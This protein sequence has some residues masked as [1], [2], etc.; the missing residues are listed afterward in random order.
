MTYYDEWAAVYLDLGRSSDPRDRLMAR[1]D[2][3]AGPDGC[4]PYL[5]HVNRLGYGQMAITYPPA[6]P[7]RNAM[8]H[9]F[10]FEVLVG[11]IPD[12]LVLDHLCRNRS[13]CNPAHLEPVTLAENTRRGGN[14]IK[15]ACKRGHEFS[16]ENTYR[17][18]RG[19]RQ[20]KACR[21]EH[22]RAARAR[23]A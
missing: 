11:P 6:A 10:A 13:C 4:W 14:A 17:D 2:R 8:A 23:A 18:A 15:T 16:D 7:W 3:S 1:I 9:R 22:S 21:R 20:C 19:R 12:G 5:G